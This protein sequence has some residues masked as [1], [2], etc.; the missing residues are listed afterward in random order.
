MI[1][2]D[3]ALQERA[4]SGS[5]IRVGMVGAGFM[6]RGVAL[7]VHTAVQG[8]ELVAIANRRLE[9]ARRA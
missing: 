6:G 7:Q 5:P 4:R 9:P 3:A 8:M 2:V 1:L